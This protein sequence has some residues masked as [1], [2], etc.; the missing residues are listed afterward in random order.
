MK[1]IFKISLFA[2]LAF[3]LGSCQKEEGTKTEKGSISIASSSEGVVISDN[4][5][6]VDATIEPIGSR[7][8]LAVTAS[9]AFK[10]ITNEQD[11]W[12]VIST[13]GNTITVSAAEFISDY[14]RTTMFRVVTEDV[15]AYVTVS[16]SGTEVVTLNFTPEEV[17]FPEMGGTETVVVATNKDTW[18][19]TGYEDSEWLE[20]VKGEDSFT[21]NAQ[22]NE[23]A[24]DFT[25]KLTVDAGAGE[26]TTSKDLVVT[27][28]S[29]SEAYI[30]PATKLVAVPLDGGNAR[31]KI[32]AN[33][34]WD[35]T[36]VSDAWITATR[37]GDELV[38]VTPDD[39]DDSNKT[40]SIVIGTTSGRGTASVT[41]NIRQV[42]NPFVLKYTV[43]N[44][45][46][47]IAVPLAGEVSCYVDWGD[48]KASSFSG[49]ITWADNMITHE[50]EEA[51]EYTVKM[52]GSSSALDT[53]YGTMGDT[54]HMVTDFVAWGD[55]GFTDLS[56]GFAGM[57]FKTIPEG[58]KNVLP[59]LANG[60]KMDRMFNGCKNLEVIPADLFEGCGHY[61][62][63]NAIFW[64]CE[65]IKEIPA[66]LLDP[67]P[68]LTDASSLF[69]ETGITSIPEGL[70]AN[71][72]KLKNLVNCFADSP[73]LATI[74]A[75]LFAPC[76]QVTNMLGL[77]EN[78]TSLI[79]V[80]EG[81]FD[82]NTEVTEAGR[83]FNGCT[84]LTTVPVGI[85]DNNK[86]ITSVYEMFNGC[87]LLT[88]SS[89]Y[90]T[91]NSVNVHLYERADYPE[92][93][94]TP[95]TI[96]NC[97]TGCTGLSDYDDIPADWK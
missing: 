66:G 89:P 16:Q 93:F 14:T 64:R 45:N 47:K 58:Y 4:G 65:S 29:W 91:V 83:L 20:V 51:G 44:A 30:T 52:Y 61:T 6:T 69:R 33:R 80:P 10:L 25:V 17:T 70:F 78:C 84:K 82:T 5:R 71:Q 53:I 46:T 35:I 2:L 12:C 79:T 88:G 87:T 62:N 9:A 94:T 21:L 73:K 77:F 15:A 68:E 60:S 75:S 96:R 76:T 1:N 7:F 36:S 39:S 11:D 81:L 34:Q 74:P 42:S 67:M 19:V 59:T 55:M 37:D 32:S 18:N 48:G 28:K 86:K 26:N 85:L 43:P 40:G 50:Y 23:V 24:R 72:T 56:S 90:T 27:L 3:T 95:N 97:F 13:E 54:R 63:V 8:E 49:T 38:I 22:T 92:T 41:I 31:V 57:S